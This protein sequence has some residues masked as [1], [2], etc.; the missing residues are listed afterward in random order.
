M[1]LFKGQ[2][3]ADFGEWE[4]VPA[5]A[6]TRTLSLDF[7]TYCDLDLKKFGLDLY[8]IHPSCEVLMCG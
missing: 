7:E 5:E 4:L 1:A 6:P 2:L 8:S 3:D